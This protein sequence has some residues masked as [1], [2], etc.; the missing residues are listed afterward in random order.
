MVQQVAAKLV[1]DF[2]SNLARLCASPGTSAPVAEALDA[3]ELA[4]SVARRML[5]T[6]RALAALGVVIALGLLVFMGVCR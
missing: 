5:G 3:V 1:S 4:G 2:S 6:P